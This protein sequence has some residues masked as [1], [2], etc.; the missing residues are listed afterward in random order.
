MAFFSEMT[1][2][3]DAP[4]FKELDKRANPMT[5]TCP[6]CRDQRL[7]NGVTE[8]TQGHR[9]KLLRLMEKRPT[10]RHAS[11]AMLEL[12]TSYRD[13]PGCSISPRQ[14]VFWLQKAA[15]LG[16]SQ[17]QSDLGNHYRQGTGGLK[18]DRG[19]ACDLYRLAAEAGSADAQDCLAHKYLDGDGVEV[20]PKKA[21]SWFL[22]AAEQG[23]AN[24]QSYCHTMLMQGHGVATNKKES[25]IWAEKAATQGN[26]VAMSNVANAYMCPVMFD[27]I[28]QQDM[29]KAKMWAQ[30]AA[31]GGLESSTRML[32]A[33]NGDDGASELNNRYILRVMREEAGK[34]NA[35]YQFQL[36]LLYGTDEADPDAKAARIIGIPYDLDK[37]IKWITRASQQGLADAQFQLGKAYMSERGVT[38]DM[39][40]ALR[41]LQLATDQGHAGATKMVQDINEARLMIKRASEEA[42]AQKEREVV[43][44]IFSDY[45]ATSL[46]TEGV[47]CLKSNATDKVLIIPKLFQL[48]QRLD[49]CILAGNKYAQEILL[50]VLTGLKGFEGRVLESL[51]SMTP[52]TE[53]IMLAA[54]PDHAH[55]F[56]SNDTVVGVWKVY[57]DQTSKQLDASK[58]ASDDTAVVEVE[59]DTHALSVV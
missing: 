26:L 12:A 58:R 24:A 37:S 46:L 15:A 57:L 35:S 23:H 53:A 44:D 16:L 34:G 20:S 1:S 41:L 25:F 31:D 10:G 56:P 32:A 13:W 4:I 11:F 28:V 47:L 54:Y 2:F 27:N 14:E 6:V 48:I 40:E 38:L 51:P 9:D 39:A 5:W 50:F 30:R 49:D 8:S 43:G 36:G 59:E 7:D 45:E 19:K 55:T 21:Y 3:D 29:E 22:K 42:R 17:A 52:E 18:E 33:L